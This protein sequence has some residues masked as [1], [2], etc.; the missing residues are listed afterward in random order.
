[1]QSAL[2]FW[3]VARTSPE[4]ALD[5]LGHA[6]IIVVGV[7]VVFVDPFDF[8]QTKADVQARQISRVWR[9]PRAE[10]RVF[11]Q[12]RQVRHLW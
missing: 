9:L 10:P 11:V 1:M 12:H 5:E 7:V 6:T 2:F 8:S 4:H 3:R